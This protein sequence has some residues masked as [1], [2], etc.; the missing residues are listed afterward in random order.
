MRIHNVTLGNA[1][2]GKIQKWNTTFNPGLALI[3]LSREPGPVE[4]NNLL[5]DQD[6]SPVLIG[7]KPRLILHT[8]LALTIQLF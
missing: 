5:F 8:Q 3:G 2:K 1:Y 7:S 4:R 6:I